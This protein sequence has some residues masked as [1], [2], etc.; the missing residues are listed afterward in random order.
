MIVRRVDWEQ[1]GSDPGALLGPGRAAQ[2]KVLLR[3]PVS[4][5]VL[6]VG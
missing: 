3:R 2:P 6:V 1:G 5:A 4:G